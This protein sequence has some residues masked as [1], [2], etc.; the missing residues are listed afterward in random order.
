MRV[1]RHSAPVMKQQFTHTFFLLSR[2]L[3]ATLMIMINRNSTRAMENRACL[4]KSGG[5]GHLAGHGG[6]QEPDGLEQG[7]ACWPRCPPPS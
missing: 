4:C 2:L 5:I 3:R 1:R 7:R 6:G